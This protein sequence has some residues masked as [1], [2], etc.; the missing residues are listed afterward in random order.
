MKCVL[1]QK[2]QKLHHRELGVGLDSPQV[3]THKEPQKVSKLLDVAREDKKT[4]GDSEKLT[5]LLREE[6]NS[7]RISFS[8]KLYRFITYFQLKI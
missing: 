6:F 7:I 1:E 3:N 5:H 4:K 2:C 8:T